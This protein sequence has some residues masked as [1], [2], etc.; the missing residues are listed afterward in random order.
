MPASGPL[1]PAEIGDDPS[2]TILVIEGTPIVPSG[3]WTEPMDLD[4]TKMQGSLTAN[5]GI[6]PGGLLGEG[7]AFATVDG[8]AHF[9]PTRSNRSR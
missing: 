1:A 5:P 4:I 7:V 8:R 9:V 3:L 6:E 2:Q